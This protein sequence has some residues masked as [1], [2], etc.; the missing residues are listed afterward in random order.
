MGKIVPLG[1]RMST[2]QA[3]VEGLP[4]RLN[5]YEAE[6]V[7]QI[8]HSNPEKIEA[9]PNRSRRVGESPIVVLARPSPSQ[10]PEV[11]HGPIELEQAS[12]LSLREQ[13]FALCFLFLA[14]AR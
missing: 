1:K 11:Q 13:A 9:L 14:L 4:H 6:G 8:L 5:R 12:Q 3:I 7:L 10:E 2:V